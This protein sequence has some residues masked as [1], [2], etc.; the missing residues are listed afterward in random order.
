MGLQN[1]GL[2]VRAPPLLPKYTSKISILLV[3]PLVD[4]KLMCQSD[5]A[6]FADFAYLTDTQTDTLKKLPVFVR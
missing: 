2:G 5:Y 4:K 1:R 6:N 3:F